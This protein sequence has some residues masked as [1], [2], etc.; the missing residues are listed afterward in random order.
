[1]ET[2]FII[3]FA[4]LAI[5]FLALWLDARSRSRALDRFIVELKCINDTLLRIGHKVTDIQVTL[6]R[7]GEKEPEEDAVPEELP[8]GPVTIEAVHAALLGCGIPEDK[9]DAH[10]PGCIWFTVGKT[11][12]S[13][14]VSD[15]PYMVFQLRFEV[16][17]EGA[18]YDVM[19]LASDIV[20]S[21]S[22]D[23]KVYVSP[24][25]RY[26]LCHA[27]LEPESD[28]SLRDDIKR[29]INHILD[30]CRRFVDKYEKLRQEKQDDARRTL[31]TAIMAV[32]GGAS[33]KKI[34]S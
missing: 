27:V 32:Q 30:T 8:G 25:E 33:G 21:S 3:I 14:N 17:D 9:I 19:M 2:T 20:S 26:Y 11:H 1:M 4:A 10:D 5:V 18:D 24:V 22:P 31:D 23:V 7:M 6:E 16:K 34:P 29:T 15:L 13:V 28:R 12:L